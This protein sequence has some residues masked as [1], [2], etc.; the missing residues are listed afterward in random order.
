MVYSMVDKEVIK[1]GSKKIGVDRVRKLVEREIW[2]F[3]KGSRW[4][5]VTD[6]T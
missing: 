6:N 5:L 3:A 1:E 2:K 4:W